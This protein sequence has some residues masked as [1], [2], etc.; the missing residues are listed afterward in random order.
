M[1]FTPSIYNHSFCQSVGSLEFL[2]PDRD[3][4]RPGLPGNLDGRYG[5][6]RHSTWF[7]VHLLHPASQSP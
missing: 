6:E 1:I 4:Q 2:Y 5:I 7:A 3:I